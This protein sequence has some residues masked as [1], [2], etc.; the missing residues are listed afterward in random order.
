M[1]TRFSTSALLA[2]VDALRRYQAQK[3]AQ[4]LNRQR[5]V[6]AFGESAEEKQETLSL[7]FTA[8][9]MTRNA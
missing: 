7:E 1:N 5:L 4:E 6:A 3:A 9:P 2:L 8:A